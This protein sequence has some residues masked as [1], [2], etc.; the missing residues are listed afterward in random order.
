MRFSVADFFAGCGGLSHG[1]GR[2]GLYETVL[3]TDIDDAALST[4][5]HNHRHYGSAPLLVPGDIQ[6]LRP[7]Q[8]Q[9]LLKPLQLDDPG[10]VDVLMGGPPCE[11]FSQNRREEIFSSSGE[12]VFTRNPL[13]SRDPRN[14]LFRYFLSVAETLRPKAVLIENVPQMTTAHGGRFIMEIVKLL[15]ALGYNASWRVLNAAAYGVP[16]KRRRA[17]V[18]AT[19]RDLPAF[20]WPAPTHGAAP[21]RSDEQELK[22]VVTVRDAISDLPTATDRERGRAA[23]DLYGPAPSE[24]AMLMRSATATPMNHVRRRPGDRVLARLQ[25]MSPGMRTSE[26]P[27]QLKPKS[28]Y[29]NCY[30]RMQWDQPAK[31]ITKSCN[32]L[33]SGCFGHPEELRGITMREAARLQSFDDDFDFL[34]AS[35]PHVAKMIGGAVPPLLASAL[36]EAL[37]KSLDHA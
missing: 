2:T 13:D 9:Q 4:F 11:G 28:H 17:F 14:Q 5:A 3:A 7:Q 16:Q 25:A 30:G 22:A 33:G 24:F 32:Y 27:E 37:A 31:T 23:V 1:F 34:S 36:A 10:D 15:E 18:V 12:R 8:F 26:L 6:D 29:Y 20:S 35:E 19:R 21:V